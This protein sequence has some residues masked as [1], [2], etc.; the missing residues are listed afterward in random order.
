MSESTSSTQ[1]M[2]HKADLPEL[3]LLTEILPDRVKSPQPELLTEVMPK[4]V[5]KVQIID[6]DTVCSGCSC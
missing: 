1:T 4:R 5:Y 2:S 6:E 3:E